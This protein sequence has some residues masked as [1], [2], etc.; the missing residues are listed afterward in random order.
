ML[1]A[2]LGV[3]FLL[4]SRNDAAGGVDHRAE[5]VFIEAVG[6][7]LCRAALGAVAGHQEVGMGHQLS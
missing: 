3:F 1:R 5:S 7:I 4:V 2:E 6:Q